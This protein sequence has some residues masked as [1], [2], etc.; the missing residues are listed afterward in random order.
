MA[1]GRLLEACTPT[2]VLTDAEYNNPWS[3]LMLAARRGG[4]PT[5]TMIHGVICGTYGYTPL[6]SDAA[7][8]WGRDQ[9]E[10]M[11]AQGVEPE[12]LR[13]TGCQRLARDSKVAGRD[14]RLRLR[15][16]AEMPVAMLATGPVPREEW[17]RLVFAFGDAFR[18][19]TGVCPVVRLHASEKLDDFKA[20]MSQFPEMR[21]LENGQWTVEA[22]MAACDVVVIHNSGLGNDALVFNR[23]VVLLDVLATPMSNGRVLAEKAGSPMARTPAELRA[24]SRPDSRG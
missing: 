22:P 6:L 12:R 7:F 16:P 11:I 18:G 8:C 14:V 20:E 19:H 9:V 23:L 10:Q 3:C 5:A 24:I 17:R 21:F 13:I 4:I 1:F 2:V 15:L